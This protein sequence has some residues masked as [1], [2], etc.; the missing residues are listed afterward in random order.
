V[1][2]SAWQGHHYRAATKAYYH[3]KWQN[4]IT[5]LIGDRCL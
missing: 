3:A 5:N 1:A 2:R 4:T